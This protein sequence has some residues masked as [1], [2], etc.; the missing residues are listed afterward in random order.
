MA[1]C[2]NPR[3]GSCRVKG[4]IRS[5]RGA[6]VPTAAPTRER[7]AGRGEHDRTDRSEAGQDAD[8]RAPAG[9]EDA[10]GRG[11][12]PGHPRCVE[13]IARESPA[14]GRRQRSSD[15]SVTR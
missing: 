12:R 4:S 14:I 9:G 10:G 15:G 1:S 5:P 13:P 7:P 8:R 6:P 2:T 11:H 3:Q